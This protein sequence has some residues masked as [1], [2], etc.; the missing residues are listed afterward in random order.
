VIPT[1]EDVFQ[2]KLAENVGI[3]TQ[4]LAMIEIARKFPSAVTP[5]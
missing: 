2:E 1:V 3:T 4:Y 5:D